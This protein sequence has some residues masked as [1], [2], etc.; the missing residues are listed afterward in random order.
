MSYNFFI[1]LDCKLQGL[2]YIKRNFYRADYDAINLELLEINWESKLRS[3]N[4]KL[5]IN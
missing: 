4:V 1:K 2:N 5:L 3:N